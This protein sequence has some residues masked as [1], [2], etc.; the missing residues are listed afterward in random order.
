[1]TRILI[2]EDEP[3]MCM[4]LKDNL[5]FEGYTV[6]TAFDG[7]TGFQL[8]LSQ[9]PDLILLDSMLPLVSGFDVCKEL[10]NRGLTIPIIMLTAR[11]E[12][13]DK[14]LGLELG[15]DDYIT[16]PF[17]IRELISR[18]KAVLR[19]TEK[20]V[21]SGGP[22]QIGKLEV[23]FDHY[24]ASENG[25]PVE[26]SH[27]EFELLKYFVEHVGETV[28]REQLLEKVWGYQHGCPDS[29]TVDN[30]M[31]RLRKKIEIDSAKPRHLRTVHGFGY[32]LII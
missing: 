25:K 11:G 7:K 8:S 2:I 28:T 20:P 31:V 1:M 15:A 18:I 10:R 29:R 19:R 3:Q 13:T 6:F 17:S 4:G 30:F 23:D 32:K 14:I 16:K 22:Y 21:S 27:R 9:K 24:H 5:E 26:L 12:E